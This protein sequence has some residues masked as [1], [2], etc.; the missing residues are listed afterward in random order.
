[1]KILFFEFIFLL[2]SGS[3]DAS[4]NSLT[5]ENKDTHQKISQ[6]F[7]ANT[8]P[9]KIIFGT[10][11]DKHIAEDEFKKFQED[12]LYAK[13]DALAKEND[14]AIHIRPWDGYTILVVELIENQ[15]TEQKVLELMQPKF[16]DIYSIWYGITAKKFSKSTKN[17]ESQI[18]KPDQESV[19]EQREINTSAAMK[20]E[21]PSFTKEEVKIEASRASLE[22]VKAIEPKIEPKKIVEEKSYTS[23]IWLLIL[24]VLTALTLLFVFTMKKNEQEA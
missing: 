11:S 5:A 22:N 13:V 1:M 21:A 19:V 15:A 16:E 2:I 14:F 18:N 9:K 12:A 8:Y 3:L 7:L 10:F 24:G 23:Y 17:K 20:Q 4:S 6:T